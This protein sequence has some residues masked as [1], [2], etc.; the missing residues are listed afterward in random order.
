[1]KIWQHVISAKQLEPL[2]P[3]ARVF[4]DEKSGYYIITPYSY[5]SHWKMKVLNACVMANPITPILTNH[6]R[7]LWDEPKNG[8]LAR[9]IWPDQYVAVEM[10]SPCCSAVIDGSLA[11]GVAMGSCS[12]C[13][14]PV[15]R[16]NRATGVQEWLDGESPWTEKKLRPVAVRFGDKVAAEV[17]G[18]LERL[19]H[20]GADKRDRVVRFDSA[21]LIPP[22]TLRRVLISRRHYFEHSREGMLQIKFQSNGRGGAN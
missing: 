13:G 3:D 20:L 15:V 16:L 7:E 2:E 5:G 12:K 18:L 19:E 17:G 11:D 9:D 8:K 14:K 1:M 4:S 6:A 22:V 21:V 10:R